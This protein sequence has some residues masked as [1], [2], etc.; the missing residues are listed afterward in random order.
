[1][2]LA[3]FKAHTKAAAF[4]RYRKRGDAAFGRAT[5][6]VVFFVCALNAAGILGLRTIYDLRL[7]MTG[8]TVRTD[9]ASLLSGS[10]FNWSLPAQTE[11]GRR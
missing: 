9:A 3:P 2:I 6:F 5:S 4:G 10:I 1:M 7:S 11:N 8:R